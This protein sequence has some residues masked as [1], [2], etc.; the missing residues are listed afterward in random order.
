[1]RQRL[2]HCYCYGWNVL[3]G[4]QIKLSPPIYW[5]ISIDPT[6]L[7]GCDLIVVSVKHENRRGFAGDEN[8]FSVCLDGNEGTNAYDIPPSSDLE[9][10]KTSHDAST[11]FNNGHTFSALDFLRPWW[12][13]FDRVVF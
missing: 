1:M 2:R 12:P 4:G 6:I 13:S 5:I 9:A 3:D 10:F 11:Y 7:K 8:A